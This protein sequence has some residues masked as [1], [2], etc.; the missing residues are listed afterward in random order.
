MKVYKADNTRNIE[1]RVWEP[2]VPGAVYV[3]EP[4]I[5][6]EGERKALADLSEDAAWRTAVNARQ[7]LGAALILASI[8]YHH[9][10][11]EVF[12]PPQYL[13]IQIPVVHSRV[14]SMRRRLG[15]ETYS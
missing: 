15:K 7:F 11:G 13:P 5:L 10:R 2:P 14:D 9:D 3:L 1:L 6:T 4:N 8:R 12:N